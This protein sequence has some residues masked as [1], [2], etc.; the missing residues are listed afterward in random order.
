[1]LVRLINSRHLLGY[2][3]L[4]MICL[5]QS[6]VT[7]F[8]KEQD[9][10]IAGM[11]LFEFLKFI[12]LNSHFIHSLLWAMV[13]FITAIWLSKISEKYRLFEKK[14]LM[15]AFIFILISGTFSNFHQYNPVIFSA[16]FLLLLVNILYSTYRKEFIFP[17]A[18][19]AGFAV[20]MASLFYFPTI[21]FLGLIWIGFFILRAFNWREWVIPVLGCFVPY[22]FAFTYFYWMDDLPGL[23]K[24]MWIPVNLENSWTGF[25]LAEK[26]VIGITGLLLIVSVSGFMKK[27]SSGNIAKQKYF[28]I[29]LWYIALVIVS[30]IVFPISIISHLFLLVM[31]VSLIIT[32][33]L[34]TIKKNWYLELIIWTMIISVVLKFFPV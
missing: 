12:S 20:G 27:I 7:F 5:L 33:Y 9:L 15:P 34:D 6:L 10:G 25:T 11:P 1:M 4:V 30:A 3:L 28:L 17:K 8:F 22:F 32:S 24:N 14:S 16:I 21:I 31:P 2:L 26:T 18:F 19:D 23:F 13:V 29:I